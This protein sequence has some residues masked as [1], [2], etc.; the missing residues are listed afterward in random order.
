MMKQTV[1]ISLI[2]SGGCV[3]CGGCNTVAWVV[4]RTEGVLP[5]IAPSFTW[6]QSPSKRTASAP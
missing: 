3:V 6:L 2:H 4:G 1:G 5:R